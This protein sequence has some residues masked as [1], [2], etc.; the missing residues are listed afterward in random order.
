MAA[1]RRRQPKGLY[2]LFLTEMWERFGF[3]TMYGLFVLYLTKELEMADAAATLLFGAFASYLYV[4]TLPG[5]HLADRVLGFRRAIILGAAI[6]C[7]GYLSL[8]LGD[9]DLVPVS[10]GILI[11]GNGFFKPNVGALLGHLYDE[12]DPRR[13]SGFTI[14]YLGI[15][16][17]SFAAFVVAGWVAQEV[18]YNWA[19]GMAGIGKLI[20]MATFIFGRRY[21]GDAGHAPNPALLKQRHLGLPLMWLILIG[22]VGAAGIA[23]Y[24]MHHDV[25]AGG[26]LALAALVAFA[27]FLY[28]G[29]RERPNIRRRVVV[30]VVLSAFSIVFWSVYVQVGSS[31]LLFVDRSVDRA[32]LG[33]LVPASEFL[34]LN[35]FFILV[36]G[37]PFAALWL[38]LDKFRLNPSTPLKF[39]FGFLLIGSSYFILVWGVASSTDKVAW[40]WL[41]LF[42][43]VYTAAEMVLS[44]VGLAMSTDLAPKRLTGL[45][46][47]IWLLATS[48]GLYVGG[49][50]ASVAAVPKGSSAKATRDIYETGFADFGWIALATGMLLVALVPWLNHLIRKTAETPSPSSG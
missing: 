35:P 47:G 32:I 1:T 39:V 40:E 22:C 42:F 37:M 36:M 2:I 50:L 30:L 27:Y 44:P 25:A 9:V 26:V 31:F 7:V 14:F 34:S 18:G 29:W 41:V 10:L 21:L 20:S 24:M 4:T 13:E 16:L 28:E 19:F 49:V 8:T 33:V 43:A 46:M 11:V 15:N 38:W 5:G 12:D 45:A 48:G 23:T 3:Y 17:G 6:M